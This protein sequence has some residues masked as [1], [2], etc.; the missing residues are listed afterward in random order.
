MIR[1][2]CLLFLKNTSSLPPS[3]RGISHHPSLSSPTEQENIAKGTTDSRVEF[4][5]IKV[6]SFCHIT[7]SCTNLDQVSSS[8]S[9]PT[10]RR[11]CP[12]VKPG[13]RT[14]QHLL[15]GALLRENPLWKRG[16]FHMWTGEQRGA[17]NQKLEPT[18]SPR[19]YWSCQGHIHS[20]VAGQAEDREAVITDPPV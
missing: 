10:L 13:P 19:P 20:I 8:E 17:I 5:L 4:C 6:T 2:S 9:Q 18:L 3:P 11:Q 1:W 12:A 16:N 14:G 15:I 7:S